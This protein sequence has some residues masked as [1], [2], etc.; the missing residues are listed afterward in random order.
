MLVHAWQ[1]LGVLRHLFQVR[2]TARSS[3]FASVAPVSFA[4]NLKEM[5]KQP[6]TEIDHIYK[7]VDAVT[8]LYEQAEQDMPR[9]QRGIEKVVA[10]LGRPVFLVVYVLVVGLWVVGNLAAPRMGMKPLDEPPFFWL[11]GFVT[12]NSLL[13]TIVIL[14]AQH[15]QSRLAERRA[16]LDLQ[17]NLLAESKIAKVISLLE[18]LR[19]DSPSVR[20][21]YDGVAEAMQKP[22]DP[23]LVVR[24]LDDK[25]TS[26]D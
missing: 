23:K 2:G 8:A 13:T 19:R 4:G 22:A 26:K 12:A 25:N 20:D 14:I 5:T 10:M 24:A 9:G 18:E 11:Q 3:R 6:A 15:R 7:N 1:G 17:V 21:R 16:H